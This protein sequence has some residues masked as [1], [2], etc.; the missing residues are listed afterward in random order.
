MG[1]L[2]HGAKT[3]RLAS[4]SAN[5]QE[6]AVVSKICVDAE[7][8]GEKRTGIQEFQAGFTQNPLTIASIPSLYRNLAGDEYPD[9]SA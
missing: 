3:F 2:T 5:V 6:I 8:S 4:A 9:A 1:T 7:S